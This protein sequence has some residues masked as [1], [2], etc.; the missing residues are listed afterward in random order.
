[1]GNSGRGKDKGLPGTRGKGEAG[2]NLQGNNSRADVNK[3]SKE[4]RGRGCIEGGTKVRW[5][6]LSFEG[7]QRRVLTS[8][9][10]QL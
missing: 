4:K 7:T 6:E 2:G 10:E 9:R 5:G 3:E 1:M 8:G